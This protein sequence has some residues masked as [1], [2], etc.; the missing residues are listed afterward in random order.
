MRILMLK[1]GGADADLV[2]AQLRRAGIT[3]VDHVDSRERFVAALER[4]PDA[5]VSDYML[6]QFEASAVI[7]LTQRLQP[8][9]P[10]IVLTGASEPRITVEL[11]QAGAASVVHRSRL[12]L[13]YESIVQAVAERAELRKLSERQIQVLQLIAQGLTNPEIAARLDISTKTV[14]THRTHLMA[15]LDIHHVAT[16]VRYAIRLGMV[17]LR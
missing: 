7:K 13:L 16:L 6:A 8:V 1:D 9:T 2:H 11:L 14:E 15:R 17:P 12:D 5:I 4:N 10:V 3:H